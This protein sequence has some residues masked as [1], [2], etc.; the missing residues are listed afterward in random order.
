[1][2]GYIAKKKITRQRRFPL[3]LMLEPLHACNLTCTGCGRI[4][5]YESTIKQKLTVEECLDSVEECGAP[6]VS[7]CGGEPMIYPEIGRLT[8]EILK[9]RR[10]IYLCTNGMFIKKK[11]HEFRPTS[12]FFFNV[13]LDGL[14]ETHDRAVEREGVFDAAVEGIQAAKAAGFQICTNTTVYKDTDLNEIDALYAY[15]TRLGVD[16]FMMSPAYGYVAVQETN[17]K[18]AAEIFLTRDDI[19]AK[20]KEAS[21]LLGKYKLTASPV[22]LEFLSGEREL[23]CTA[24]GNPTRN[25]K[26]WKGPCYLITDEHH[27]TFKDLMENTNW[28]NYG[29]G[30]DKRCEHCMVHCGYEPSAALGVNPRFGDTWKMLKWQLT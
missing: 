5:E 15:L 30:K 3:V 14:R 28:D 8:R 10:H 19:R 1:M 16:G 7:I 22:Y 12:R 11:L 29:Y 13:H 25:I 24:W 4:R 23:T 21:L 20:F 18:G 17:P 2:A 26:G 6:I 9:R 27:A